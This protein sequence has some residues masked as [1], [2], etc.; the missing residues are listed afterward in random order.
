[1]RNNGT[2]KYLQTRKNYAF[3]RNNC[4]RNCPILG[5]LEVSS[6]SVDDY[7]SKWR[8]TSGFFFDGKENKLL[9]EK[10]EVQWVQDVAND[11]IDTDL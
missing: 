2:Q 1:M 6:S 7:Y 3:N 5:Q 9:K 8:V 10:E 4:G 11:F